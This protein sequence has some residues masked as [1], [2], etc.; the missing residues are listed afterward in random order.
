MQITS[1]RLM[2]SIRMITTRGTQTATMSPY[3]VICR[4]TFAPE[5]REYSDDGSLLE[6]KKAVYLSDEFD[7][8][9]ILINVVSPR[10]GEPLQ[11]KMDWMCLCLDAH[12]HDVNTEHAI[13]RSPFKVTPTFTN[14]AN[15]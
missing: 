8:A 12:A 2:S 9:A 10:V 1:L 15:A 7:N 11:Y 5:T 4:S 14:V 3:S 13:F 6:R